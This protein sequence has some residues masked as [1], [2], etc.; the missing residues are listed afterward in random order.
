MKKESKHIIQQQKTSKKI[1]AYQIGIGGKFM[2]PIFQEKHSKKVN[3][4]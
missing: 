4:D 1:L 3:K 2:A